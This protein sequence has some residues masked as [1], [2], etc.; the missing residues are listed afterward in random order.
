VSH[1]GSAAAAPQPE[2]AVYGVVAE[3]NS[4]EA[5]VRA[6]RSVR[7]AGYTKL[8][9]YSPFPIHGIDEAMGAR[10]SRL[11]FIVFG[12]GLMG[13]SAALM[14]QWWTGTV[15]YPLVI[16]GKPLFAIEF[17]I[18]ITFELTVLFAA[19]GAVFG[20]LGFNGL[21]RFY[22]PIFQHSRFAAVTD[23]AFLLA[24]ESEGDDFQPERAVDVLEALGGRNAE[25]IGE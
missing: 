12:M 2:G 25:V 6:A 8:D 17:S 7:K 15:A 1:S 16:G 24:I 21:P 9:A 18:P 23:D 20:M 19:F 5:L 13:L 3:F 4:A 11:G 22:H 10:R 14:L